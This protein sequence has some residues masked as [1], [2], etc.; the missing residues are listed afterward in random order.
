LRLLGIE[1]FQLIVSFVATLPG[2]VG[3]AMDR[4]RHLD[5]IPPHQEGRIAIAKNVEAGSG[6][7]EISQRASM[8]RGTAV[9]FS[10]KIM[11]IESVW[12]NDVSRTAKKNY[13]ATLTTRRLMGVTVTPRR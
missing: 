1:L 2:W 4:A 6:G 7:R 10:D 13:S 8:I 3:Q 11:L 12:T 5:R 9:R